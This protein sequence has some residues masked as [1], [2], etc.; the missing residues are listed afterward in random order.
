MVLRLSASEFMRN[1][2]AN[3]PQKATAY[4]LTAPD[5]SPAT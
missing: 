3:R 5:V 2:Y 4:P 1:L